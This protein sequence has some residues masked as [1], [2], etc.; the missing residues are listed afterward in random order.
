[1]KNNRVRS[2]SFFLCFYFCLAF[3]YLTLLPVSGLPAA[4]KV[5]FQIEDPSQEP[6][7]AK[8]VFL[9]LDEYLRINVRRFP[10][11]DR[12]NWD[13]PSET[14]WAGSKQAILAPVGTATVELD[15]GS[16]LVI[17]TRGL[18]YS[19]AG[20]TVTLPEMED[21]TFVF[22]LEHLLDVPGRIAVDS[23][24]HSQ[25][26]ADA[27]IIARNWGLTYPYPSNR[28]I[29]FLT[30]GINLVVSSEHSMMLDYDPYIQILADEI[31]ELDGFSSSYVLEKI[32]SITGN[33]L[34]LYVPAEGSPPDCPPLEDPPSVAHFNAWPLEEGPSPQRCDDIYRQPAT[35][36]DIV[37]DLDSIPGDR[38]V[39]QLNHPRG[40]NYDWQYLSGF[41]GGPHLGYFHNWLYDPSRP[42]PDEYDGSTNSFLRIESDSSNTQ[43]IDFDVIEILN[44][45]YMPYYMESRQD[46]FSLLNQGFRKVATGNTDSH[47]IF[48]DGAGYPRNYVASSVTSME[49]FG[50]DEEN[51]VVDTVLYGDIF[52]TTGPVID[53]S[54]EG[55]GLGDTIYIDSPGA[56][57]LSISIMVRAVPWVPVHQVRVISNG[58]QLYSRNIRPVIPDDPYSTDPSD[59][60]RYDQSLN[61]VFNED[62]WVIVEAGIKLPAPG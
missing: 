9:G 38:E 10:N 45:N 50:M 12:L 13:P 18:E 43:N 30:T 58:E 41:I 42:I 7:P 24:V 40:T 46:W 4:Y 29:D 51:A 6:I 59:L 49:G 2:P 23:H 5:N 39:I 48:I 37:R 61:R 27:R 22:T 11:F 47:W 3:L 31:G 26:S 16:Y 1:M 54:I 20:D 60:V 34:T 21:T 19:I 52:V 53:F 15:S 36:Y 33:E 25:A 28:I 56:A 32:T 55:V 57:Q 62:A 44:R 35:L 14:Y 8:L 17:A